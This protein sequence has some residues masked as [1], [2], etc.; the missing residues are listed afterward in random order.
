[1][2]MSGYSSRDHA[3]EGKLHDLWAKTLV[4]ED[5][6]GGRA[7]L[8]TLDLVG[9]DRALSLAIRG[10]LEKKYGLKKSQVAINCSHTHTGPVVGHNLRAMYFLDEQQ[11]RLIDEY[12]AG[13][14]ARVIAVVGEAIK[15]LAPA[16]PRRGRTAMRPLPSTGAQISSLRCQNWRPRGNCK[17]RSITMCPSW[18]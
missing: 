15:D 8:V 1:M 14:Q 10:E 11:S 4:L 2:W 12:T 6:T 13:L 3:A 17:A 16:T 18:L 5:A 7:V 9:I